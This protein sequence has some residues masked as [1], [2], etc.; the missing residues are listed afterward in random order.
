MISL[1]FVLYVPRVLFVI[2][3]L[4]IKINWVIPNCKPEGGPADIG[5]G[6]GGGRLGD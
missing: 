5:R 2:C 6:E 3:T 1:I 4:F